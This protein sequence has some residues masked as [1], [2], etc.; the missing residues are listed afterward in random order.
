V[1]AQDE[2]DDRID[3]YVLGTMA[4]DERPAFERELRHDPALA[5]E[6]RAVQSV[7]V[8]LLQAVPQMSPPADLR[9]RVLRAAT[10]Q[11]PAESSRDQVP[12][13]HAASPLTEAPRHA[14]LAWPAWVAAA[15]SIAVALGLGSYTVRL[16][17]DVSTLQARLDAATSRLAGAESSVAR[18]ERAVSEA[19][20]QTAVL[21]APDL[22]QVAL[23]GQPAAPAARARAFWSRSRGLVFTASQLPPLP[24]GR[25][26][27]LWVVTANARISAGVLALAGDGR[28]LHIVQTPADIPTP[29]AM[30]VTLEPEGGVPQPTGA[31]YL[32]GTTGL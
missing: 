24:T 28:V 20:S 27:Q 13:A 7:A 18:M 26:Y 1:T 17:Q 30:A 31:F 19:Q 11:P 9:A 4:A 5:R 14:P 32:L 25:S 3:A 12:T 23:A 16:K 10:G 8:G 29:V 15:A 6:V 22:A 21:S 2:R